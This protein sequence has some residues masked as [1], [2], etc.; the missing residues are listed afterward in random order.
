LGWDGKSYKEI[1]RAE[2]PKG[3]TVY[4][5]AP[6]V[7]DGKLAYSFID[8]DFRLKAMDQ[9]GKVIWRSGNTFGSDNSFQVKP[10]PSG[11]AYYEGDEFAWVNVRVISR[12]DELFI[13]RNKSPIGEFLKR[14]RYYSG[15]E[16]LGLVWNGAMF[17]ENWKS[18]EL[19]GYVVD[20][21]M[22]DVAGSQEKEL[23]VAINLPKSSVLSMEKNSALM[24][25]RLQGA[26]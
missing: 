17:S 15:G 3:P 8:A 13:I 4:G 7:Y 11:T 1:R 19:P 14:T 16:V 18:S 10:M 5:F 26:P 6:F 21:Q 12:G 9:K 25:S 24:V 2:V 20:F 23:V 22:Q